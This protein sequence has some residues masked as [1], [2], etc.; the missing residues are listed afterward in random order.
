MEG[1]E[2]HD[3]S[4]VKPFY[5]CSGEYILWIIAVESL[6]PQNHGLCVTT[7]FSVVGVY[8]STNNVIVKL[9]AASSPHIVQFAAPLTCV[10][11]VAICYRE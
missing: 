7:G 4:I 9:Y 3:Y 6:C 8:E 10:A 2:V 1:C 5:L 11:Q